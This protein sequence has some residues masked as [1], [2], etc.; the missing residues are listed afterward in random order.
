MYKCAA[1]FDQF[2]FVEFLV[3]LDVTST[4]CVAFLYCVALCCF[5]VVLRFPIVL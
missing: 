2:F 4:G 3:E 5:D 1:F